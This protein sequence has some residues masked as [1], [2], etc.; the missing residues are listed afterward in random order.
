MDRSLVE[1]LNRWFS[2][3]GFRADLDRFLALA[4][5]VVI[6]GLIVLAWVADW[7]REPERRAVLVVGA[8]GALLAYVL[9]VGLG[10]VFYRPRPFLV[11]HVH[12]LLPQVPDS[13]LFS[14]QM[15]FA[16]GLTAALLV[17]RRWFG[18]LAVVMAVSLGTARVGAGVHYP[19]D[20]A[21]GFLAGAV[22]FGLLLPLRRPVGRLVHAMATG[23]ARAAG[24]PQ[25][26]SRFLLRHGP[27]VT[28]AP[29]ALVAGAGY[30]VRALQDHGKIEA[31]SRQEA[32]LRRTPD[33]VPPDAF[34]GASLENIAE[35]RY[36][37]THAAVTGDVSQVTRELDGDIHIRIQAGGA[38]IVAEII[39]ELPF[40][41]P[42]I[43]QIVT[44]WGIVRHD[45][46]H[47][48][49]ELHPLVGWQ[50]GDVLRPG[51]PGPGTGD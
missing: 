1:S 19:S 36:K 27:L 41:P 31:A 37:A 35:G 25:G 43:G 13:S 9:N 26:E 39:P 24:R 11:L 46:F 40:A 48:W 38:F 21:V 15:A 29:L 51:S 23:E 22:C 44:V 20:A 6:A 47:N 50:P 12:A 3:T 30:G 7:G 42:H 10:H 33:R 14:D 32:L 45:G 16:G 49:W 18:V 2:A 17:A 28:A 4:P 34:P 5:L 8:L